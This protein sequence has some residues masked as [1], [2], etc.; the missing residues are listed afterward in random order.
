VYGRA[1]LKV[2]RRTSSSWR[3]GRIPQT[4]SQGL[5]DRRHGAGLVARAMIDQGGSDIHIL[6]QLSSDCSSK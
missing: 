2:A 5:L 6:L 3:W 4:K 1:A